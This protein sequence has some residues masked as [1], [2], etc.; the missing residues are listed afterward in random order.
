MGTWRWLPW[1]TRKS[2]RG[3]RDPPTRTRSRPNPC[4]KLQISQSKKNFRNKYEN[5]LHGFSNALLQFCVFRI[6]KNLSNNLDWNGSWKIF[7]TILNL[8][9]KVSAAK[10]ITDRY[11]TMIS[12]AVLRNRITL[13]L[14]SISLFNSIRIRIRIF[15]LMRIGILLLIKMIPT[16]QSAT[17]GQQTLHGSAV[18]WD[19]SLH[20]D[21]PRSFMAPFSASTALEF[22]L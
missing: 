9:R 5:I 13:I 8:K 14:T 2:T 21:R 1:P 7:Y 18:L 20:C 22:W 11:R 15:S 10:K 12:Q 19:S 6:Y 17:T 4:T 3:S 16:Y